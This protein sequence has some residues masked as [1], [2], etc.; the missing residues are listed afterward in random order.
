MAITDLQLSEELTAG[1][2]SIKYEGDMRPK[3]AS[4]EPGQENTLEEIYFD[5]IAQGMDPAEAAKK[6]REILYEYVRWYGSRW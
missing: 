3:T 1:A 6:A 2:P 5:L 4:M